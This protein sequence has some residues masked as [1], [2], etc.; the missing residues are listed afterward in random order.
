MENKTNEYVELIKQS[1]DGSLIA[2]ERI[3]RYVM[4]THM[5]RRIGRYLNRNRQADN[6]DIKQEF[7]IGVA[8]S[9]NKV[10]LDIGDPIEY[11]IAQGMYRVR[12]YI[13]KCI[14]QGTLQTCKDCGRQMRINKVD[15]NTYQ[16][17]YCGSFAVEVQELEDHNEFAL[18]NIMRDGFEEDVMQKLAIQDFKST[19]QPGTKVYELYELMIEQN[20]NRTNPQIKN[21][22]KELANNMGG[23]STTN[24]MKILDKL[25][26]KYTQWNDEY[27]AVV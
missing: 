11:I 9:I 15:K 26:N 5:K 10:K 4:D 1:Q 12:T 24:I 19:L 16:C 3:I 6:D 23:C 14:V 18:D 8:L 20:I 27:M 25:K 21:Y 2:Q 17:K 13:R 22:A 7:M